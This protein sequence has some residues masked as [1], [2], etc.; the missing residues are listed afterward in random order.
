MSGG[1]C[2]GRKV[3]TK[4]QLYLVSPQPGKRNIFEYE[5]SIQISSCPEATTPPF[6]GDWP[7]DARRRPR[8][9]ARFR[10]T[11]THPQTQEGINQTMQTRAELMLLVLSPRISDICNSKKGRLSRLR[12]PGGAFR[13]SL[14]GGSCYPVPDG[15]DA[16][17]GKHA[18]RVG[19]TI[20]KETTLNAANAVTM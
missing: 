8:T 9:G 12:L 2:Q 19:I 20:L 4:Q 3:P 14:W 13:R 6:R 11:F 15:Q 18:L 16:G 1:H 5:I 17:C 7:K 10:D